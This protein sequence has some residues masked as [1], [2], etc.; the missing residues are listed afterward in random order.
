[1][2]NM[3]YGRTLL[4]TSSH[5][6]SSSVLNYSLLNSCS[7]QILNSGHKYSSCEEGGGQF[8]TR[9]KQ[10]SMRTKSQLTWNGRHSCVV[11]P[12]KQLNP[13]DNENERIDWVKKVTFAMSQMV[14]PTGTSGR[15]RPVLCVNEWQCWKRSQVFMIWFRVRMMVIKSALETWTLCVSFFWKLWQ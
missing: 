13:Q 7:W 3:R 12:Q 11:R 8:V 1:M 5:Y 2:T 14:F 9:S 4:W 15:S 6:D 10:L